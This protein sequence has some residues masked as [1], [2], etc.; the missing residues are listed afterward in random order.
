MAVRRGGEGEAERGKGCKVR[1]RVRAGREDPV[2][3][4]SA[5]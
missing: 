4:E 2:N 1:E 3:A 5:M